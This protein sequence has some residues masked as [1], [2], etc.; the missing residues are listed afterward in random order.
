LIFSNSHYIFLPVFLIIKCD[1][2]DELFMFR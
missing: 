2:A 1:F